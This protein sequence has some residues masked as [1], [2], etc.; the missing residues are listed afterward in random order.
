MGVLDR[1]QMLKVEK[2][3]CFSTGM[4][5]LDKPMLM[6]LCLVC[7]KPFFD[8]TEHFIQRKDKNQKLKENGMFCNV[9]QGYDYYM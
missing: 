1:Q 7:A 2:A 8:S 4:R 9:R 6:C 5:K 3:L